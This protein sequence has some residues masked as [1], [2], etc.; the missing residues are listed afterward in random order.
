MCVCTCVC[1]RVHVRARVSVRVCACACVC[2]CARVRAFA[3]NGQANWDKLTVSKTPLP[4]PHAGR[5][6]ASTSISK[7]GDTMNLKLVGCVSFNYDYNGLPGE[8]CIRLLRFI[9]K[10]VWDKK[11]VAHPCLRS[12][13]FALHMDPSIPATFT[14]ATCVVSV[15]HPAWL[16]PW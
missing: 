2:V 13:L 3:W 9:L 14:R 5:S 7:T 16:R 1:V 11:E 6:G 4:L 15:S 10:L 12:I 8:Y